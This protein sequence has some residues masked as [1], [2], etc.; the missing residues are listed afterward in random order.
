LHNDRIAALA[1]FALI[2]AAEF[3]Q[4]FA[5]HCDTWCTP[6][7]GSAVYSRR[8]RPTSCWQQRGFCFGWPGAKMAQWNAG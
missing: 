3:E 5:R 7:R 8:L 2:T 4:A 1:A 6:L